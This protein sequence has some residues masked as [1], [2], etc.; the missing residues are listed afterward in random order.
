M[1]EQPLSAP[2][3]CGICGDHLLGFTQED[4]RNHLIEG[5]ERH[6]EILAERAWENA[7]ENVRGDGRGPR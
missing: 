2:E 6:A 7:K 1:V 3:R 5:G 4:Y